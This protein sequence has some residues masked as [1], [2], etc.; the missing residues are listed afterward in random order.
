MKSS[1]FKINLSL[2]LILVASFSFS[3]TPANIKFEKKIQK[4][5]RIAEGHQLTFTYT[6]TYNGTLDLSIINPKVDCSCTKVI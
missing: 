5:K 2:L 4:F 1:L 6:F 3:Q